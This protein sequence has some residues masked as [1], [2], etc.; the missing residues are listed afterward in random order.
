VGK[1]IEYVKADI[2]FVIDQIRLFAGAERNLQ[3]LSIG[4]YVPT[5]CSRFQFT[6]ELSSGYSRTAICTGTRCWKYSWCCIIETPKS[7]DDFTYGSVRAGMEVAREAVNT[8]KKVHL[9]LGG[10]APVLIFDD[11]DL[12]ELVEK[13]KEA[14]F[15]N[16]GHDCTAATR[17]YVSEKIYNQFVID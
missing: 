11:S 3:G 16:S 15:I 4:E 1:P 7:K 12:S 9:E 10:K 17:L 8:L 2:E 6:L 5:V 14:G 13:M